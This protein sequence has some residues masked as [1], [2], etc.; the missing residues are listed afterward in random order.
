MEA[1]GGGKLR[2]NRNSG[3]SQTG[4]SLDT[5]AKSLQ[6][7]SSPT[8]KQKLFH[9]Y[10]P[11]GSLSICRLHR[12]NILS[13]LPNCTALC[14]GVGCEEAAGLI[15]AAGFMTGE[16]VAARFGLCEGARSRVT[17]GRL[18]GRGDIALFTVHPEKLTAEIKG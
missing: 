8:S 2:R 1:K 6:E 11:T 13:K 9:R 15:V 18:V 7:K 4:N 14:D 12:Y 16:A 17:G 5:A 10:N 3:S